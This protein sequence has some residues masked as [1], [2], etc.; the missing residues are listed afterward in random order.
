[1]KTLL[2]STISML[3]TKE[4]EV[5]AIVLNVDNNGYLIA[6]V[7]NERAVRAV[8][9]PE[10]ISMYQKDENNQL[11]RLLGST[12]HASVIGKD[13]EKLLLSRK[14]LMQRK[15]DTYKPGD[16]VEATIN[17]FA[18]NAMYLEFDEGL[19]GKMYT[20]QITSAKVER[21][22]DLYD[23]GDKVKCVIVKKQPDG[24]FLLS[25][26]SY[27]KNNNN[28]NI[29]NGDILKCK[30]TQKLRENSGYFVEV[31][32]NPNF[33]GIFDINKHNCKINY[34][35]G[36][37]ISLRVVDVKGNKQLRFRTNLLPESKKCC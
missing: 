9:A 8:I 4:K 28:L 14:D 36:D 29:Q 21:P 18:D 23:I 25:R 30:I 37:T 1:M 5:Q 11:R 19:I 33:S 32:S 22:M 13:K 15:F 10:D 34:R 31:T 2:R 20:N 26:L 3:L 6:Q 27:Y 17:S 12:I 16:I 7:R 35:V 24:R